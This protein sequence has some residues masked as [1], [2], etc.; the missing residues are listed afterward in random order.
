MKT[1]GP[2]RGVPSGQSSLYPGQ[3]LTETWEIIFEGREARGPNGYRRFITGTIGKWFHTTIYGGSTG[4]GQTIDEARLAMVLG[5]ARAICDDE[6]AFIHNADE[7]SKAQ[8]LRWFQSKAEELATELDEEQHS[9]VV[10]QSVC[11]KY[12]RRMKFLDQLTAEWQ[13]EHDYWPE[14]TKE[15]DAAPA[16][17]TAREADTQAAVR[18]LRRTVAGVANRAGQD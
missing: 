5:I 8:T 10:R 17:N 4:E 6:S 1:S 12:Q 14:E 3:K 7:I 15:E 9:E 13:D 11:N 18:A 2:F 16:S